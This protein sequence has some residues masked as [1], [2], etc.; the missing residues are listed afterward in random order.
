MSLPAD[1]LEDLDREARRRH[2]SRSALLAV[3]V[4]RELEQQDG[5]AVDRALERVRTA[6]GAA[7]P[8]EAA[9]LVRAERER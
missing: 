9:D 6:L 2:S 5:A 3:A 7:G 8:F 4:R 1:L